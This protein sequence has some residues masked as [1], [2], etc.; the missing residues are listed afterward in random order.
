MVSCYYCEMLTGA[1]FFQVYLANSLEMT[2]QIDINQLYP[3]PA[4]RDHA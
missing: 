1:L 2:I 3:Y 4:D